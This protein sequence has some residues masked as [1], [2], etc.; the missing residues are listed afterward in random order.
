V[1]SPTALLDEEVVC[2]TVTRSEKEQGMIRTKLG[3]LGLCAVV[4]GVMAFSASAAQAETNAKWLILTS[5]G[6]H[7]TGAEL[8]ALIQIKEL[9]GNTASLLTTVL[10][11][12]F[13]LLCTSASFEENVQIIAN[14]SLSHGRVVFHGCITKLNGVQNNKCTP[15]AGGAAPGLILTNKLKGLIVLHKLEPSGTLDD[16]IRIEPLE[17]ETFAT[18]NM[19]AECPI[20]ELIPIRGKL[21]LEDSQNAFLI[22][23]VTH[24][25]REFDPLTHLWVLS[26]TFEHEAKIDGSAIVALTGA[27]EGLK[28]SGDPA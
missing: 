16:L 2:Q 19:G 6:V 11:I 4:F 28:W 26:L 1:Q 25:V 14:G 15:K 13:E 22:H 5:G 12:A 27:H 24:L 10:G 3:L 18:F 20:G 8:P 23:Q 17:G 9:E 7:K 21:Y